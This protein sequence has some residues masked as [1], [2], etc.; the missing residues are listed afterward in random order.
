MESFEEQAAAFFEPK[1][2]TLGL[3][4]PQV[5]EQDLGELERSLDLV[6][7]LIA[8]PEQLGS[9]RAKVSAE[10]ST[11]V[12]PKSTSEAQL[13][14]GALPILLT[15]KAHIL[16]RIK[17]L[18][19]LDQIAALR[20]EI[21]RRVSDATVKAELLHVLDEQR[22]DET[23]QSSRLR[24]ETESVQSALEL[25]R[26]H[27]ANEVALAEL[28]LRLDGLDRALLEKTERIEKSVTRLE[29]RSV[30]KWDVV[31]VVFAVVAALG[32]LI[33]AALGVSRWLAGG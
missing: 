31:T 30:S 24:N 20:D 4:R 21:G 23:K 33:A 12:I 1:L 2:R 8:H 29:D 25:D 32:T 18:R 22:A 27:R 9:Y 26:Q 6:N 11:F 5:D 7:E 28:K 16:D 19:P 17:L 13:D 10:T 14:V 15:R 3:S